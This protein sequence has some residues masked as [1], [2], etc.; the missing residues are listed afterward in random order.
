MRGL[1]PADKGEQSLISAS[2]ACA[3]RQERGRNEGQALVP[4]TA[5]YFEIISLL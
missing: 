2:P 3:R 1:S 4:D 5:F